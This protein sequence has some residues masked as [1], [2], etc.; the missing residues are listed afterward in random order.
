MNVLQL[1]SGT[2]LNGAIRHCYDLT[3]Q[4]ARRGH[5]VWVAHKPD[6]WILTQPLPENVELIESSLRRDR[7]ELSRLASIA[8]QLGIDVLHTHNS[9]SHFFGV[10]MARAY[11]L[12]VVATCHM[13]H[14]QPHWWWNDRVIAPTR[15]TE[16]F[17][18]WVNWVPRSRIDII[19]N[20]IDASRLKPTRSAS[21]ILAELGL[22][23]DDLI[24]SIVGEVCSRKSQHTLIQALPE[25][26]SAGLSPRLLLVGRI[27]AAYG[28]KCVAMIRKLNLESNVLMLGQRSD[29]ANLLSITKCACLPS[30]KEVMP[31][32][33]LEAMSVGLPVIAT[34]VGGVE[35]C[36]R[37][38][39][40]GF[41]VDR[42]PSAFS[43][44]LIAMARNP[45][46]FEQMGENARR[47][48]Q[49]TFSPEACLVRIEATYETACKKNRIAA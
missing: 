14:L 46:L 8:D 28:R 47:S 24:L 39:I 17:Q 7:Q 18:R 42:S 3:C 15:S 21:D 33:L 10:L 26:I 9:S 44:G 31:I 4:L 25:L 40:D 43:E 22:L 29:V 45:K 5:R 23:P 1:A 6:A 11:G 12:R 19:P 20:F 36:V 38:G 13:P 30:K 27:D 2:G 48:M 35:E 16:T 32:A 49:T 34:A 41:I 37:D